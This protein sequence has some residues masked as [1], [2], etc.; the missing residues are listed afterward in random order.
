MANEAA[1]EA[2][3]GEGGFHL[4][5]PGRPGPI[6]LDQLNDMDHGLLAEYGRGRKLIIEV[7]TYLGG[8]A[9][10]LL[11]AMPEDGRLITIDTYAAR[12]HPTPEI[13]PSVKLSYVLTRHNDNLG[14]MGVIVGESRMMAAT[15]AHGVADMVFI[16][17]AHDY[18]SVKADIEAWLPIWLTTKKARF[19]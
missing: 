18:A 1:S 4:P 17:G 5:L 12:A 15:F 13:P 16:D 11:S 19:R 3:P 2:G 14:R 10:A 7:G 6:A 8:S 9:E